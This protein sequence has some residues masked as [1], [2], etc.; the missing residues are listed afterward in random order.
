M[1]LK[2]G[3]TYFM[4]TYPDNARCTPIILTYIY[5]GKDLNGV[6][7]GAVPRYFFRYI[8]AFSV[9]DGDQNPWTKLFPDLFK[10]YGET[11]PT[12]F[13]EEQLL[14]FRSIDDLIGELVSLRDRLREQ[15]L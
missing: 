6:E 7:E 9:A 3:A 12:V 2:T 1:N 10:G 15:Q 5:L 4:V 13:A 14:G 11:V 8:P